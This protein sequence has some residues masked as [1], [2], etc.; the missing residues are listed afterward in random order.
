M[1]AWVRFVLR[2]EKA[3]PAHFKGANWGN[4]KCQQSKA[5]QEG[6]AV[7]ACG[8]G[9][10]CDFHRQPLWVQVSSLFMRFPQLTAS[11][12]FWDPRMM[13]MVLQT[14]D[15]QINIA[16]KALSTGV[17]TANNNFLLT[18][19]MDLKLNHTTAYERIG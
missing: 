8:D 9:K 2:I 17:V 15:D 10:T 5:S 18:F 14:C 7:P 12:Q 1:D 16:A 13:L 11:T 6:D 3:V 19:Y 4:W